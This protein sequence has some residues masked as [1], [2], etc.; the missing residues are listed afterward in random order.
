[1]FPM[2]DRHDNDANEYEIYIGGKELAI[3]NVAGMVF[4]E[5]MKQ[6]AKNIADNFSEIYKH[7]RENK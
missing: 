5:E 7:S 2:P 1:M 6:R 3:P 4:T